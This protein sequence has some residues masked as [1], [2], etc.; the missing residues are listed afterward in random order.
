MSAIL[1]FC[2]F[3]IGRDIIHVHYQGE[4]EKQ[5]FVHYMV[6][7]YA[8]GS[9]QLGDYQQLTELVFVHL[10]KT[11]GSSITCML[12]PSIYHSGHGNS[13]CDDPR[14]I[15]EETARSPASK[16]R[17]ANEVENVKST[18]SQRVVR[19]V[20]LEPAP[21]EDYSGFLI[22]VRNPLDRIISWFYYNHP[23][24]P[25][26]KLPR[27]R[28][29]C[30]DFA[31]FQC[32]N[33]I[34]SLSEDGL[35]NPTNTIF[36]SSDTN[37]SQKCK[38]LA[39]DSITGKRHCWHNYFNYNFTY[40]KLVQTV[41]YEQ[42]I[43]PR[44]GNRT[45]ANV[46]A[47]QPKIIF[48]L[49]TEHLEQDWARTDLMLGGDGSSE[50]KVP[51]KNE[52]NTENGMTPNKTLSYVGR[53]NLCKALCEEIQIYKMLLHLAVNIDPVSEKQSL[54]ELLH[55]CPNESRQIKDCKVD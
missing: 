50:E 15:K 16:N 28:R 51:H 43:Y 52:W 12:D 32:W 30:D 29:G 26:V 23:M 47:K 25:P 37:D 55:S 13:Q 39:W 18:I 17:L 41:E 38:E 24:Y 2:S 14:S 10:G 5:Q 33:D 42:R 21:V 40:G 11:A 4:H 19:R 7:N 36:G 20:H 3:R 9:Q 27:H 35:L 1:S 46:T 6:Q 22:T 34:Q 31:I 45:D 49:R 44:I 48:A 53:S 54:N 8:G